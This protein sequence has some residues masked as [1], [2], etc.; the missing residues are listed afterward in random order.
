LLKSREATTA[1]KRPSAASV[2]PA[3]PII[4]TLN[5]QNH[6]E[7]SVYLLRKEGELPY[8]SQRFIAHID[9]N[10][11]TPAAKRAL[12][13]STREEARHGVVLAMIREEFLRILHS[14]DELTRLNSEARE[15]RLRE[16]DET[17]IQQMR[18][19]V[20]RLLRL[21]GLQVELAAGPQAGG[22]QPTPDRPT[23]PRRP[24]RPPEPLELHEPPTFIRIV[25]DE[26]EAVSFYPE[27][28][29]YLRIETDANSM[30]HTPND[31]ERSRINIIVS[32]GTIVVRGT[33][34]LQGGRMRAILDCTSGATVGQAGTVRVELTRLGL[35]TLY[36][37]RTF[38]VVEVPPARPG[39]RSLTLPPFEVRPVEGPHDEQWAVLGWPDDVDQVASSTEMEQGTLIVYYSTVYP[40]FAHQLT[41]FEQREPGLAESFRTRYEVWLAAHSLLLYQ[42]QQTATADGS[43]AAEEEAPEQAEAQERQER[44]RMAT[45]ATLVAAR[46]IDLGATTDEAD[47]APAGD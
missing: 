33:T 30:Y 24:R 23:R 7:L 2:N 45:V 31:A 43:T 32:D 41:R 9:S 25:W 26:D 29:R 37:E 36:D 42:D 34:P 47:T 18:R 14:D 1:N 28:R 46:E 8:L 17:A 6:A 5:G 20:A 10:G 11:L 16:R 19:E 3:R 22:T 15:E 38:E 27:Q 35:P 4:L 21:H 44:C 12:F 39:Q 40:R 13:A